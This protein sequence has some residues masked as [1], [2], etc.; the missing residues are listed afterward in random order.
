[1]N[2]QTQT[3][4]PGSVVVRS[5]NGF[6]LEAEYREDTRDY[7]ASEKITGQ[8]GTNYMPGPISVEYEVKP[9]EWSIPSEIPGEDDIRKS[10]PDSLKDADVSVDDPG[11]YEPGPDGVYR[12]P[13]VTVRSSG[14]SGDF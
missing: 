12:S 7:Y 4:W 13:T 14:M 9:T 11:V 8:M 5:G 3:G 2:S 10:L 1:M 6:S